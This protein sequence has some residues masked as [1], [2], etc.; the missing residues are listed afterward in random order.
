MGAHSLGLAAALVAVV[1]VAVAV[2]LAAG[3]EVTLEAGLAAGA[4][5]SRP[6]KKGSSQRG[7]R[8]TLWC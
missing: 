2:A 4:V 5:R 3:Q 1:G 8:G 7:I 6:W